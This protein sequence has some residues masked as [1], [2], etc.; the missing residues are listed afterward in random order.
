MGDVLDTAVVVLANL[1]LILSMVLLMEHQ[2]KKRKRAIRWE[3][4]KAKGNIEERKR[5]MEIH[6]D[7]YSPFGV[8][9]LNNYD[10]DK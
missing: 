1:L 6:R 8:V 10:G 3:K 5:R 9:R 2:D 7:K 4:S